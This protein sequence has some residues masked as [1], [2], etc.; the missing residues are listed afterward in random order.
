MKMRIQ[1]II[2][3]DSG[4]TT[5][6][7]IATLE[8]RASGELIGI[9]LDEA[10]AMTGSVQRALV[11]GQAREAIERASQCP[12]CQVLRRPGLPQLHG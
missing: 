11:E 5:T 2:E 4:A 8:R 6:A 7:Q 3:N 9:S 1:L 10:K 12:D